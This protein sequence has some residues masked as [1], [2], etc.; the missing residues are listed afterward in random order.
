MSAKLDDLLNRKSY[1]ELERSEPELL[2][3]IERLVIKDKWTPQAVKRRIHAHSLQR[4]PLAVQCEQAA[5]WVL[6][7]EREGS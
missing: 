6:V 3:E 2:S 1:Q 4:W 5:R 7:L